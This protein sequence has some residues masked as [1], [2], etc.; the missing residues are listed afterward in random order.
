MSDAGMIAM[1]FGGKAL[2][3]F[4]R[5]WA[6]SRAV[7]PGV[8]TQRKRVSS[9]GFQSQYSTYAPQVAAYVGESHVEVGQ[10]AAPRPRPASASGAVDCAMVS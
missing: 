5:R 9:C 6:Y 2:A 4:D 1:E 7:I 3:S 8:T 10:T